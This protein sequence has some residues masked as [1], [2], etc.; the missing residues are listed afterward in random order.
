MVGVGSVEDMWNNRQRVWSVWAWTTCSNVGLVLGPIYGAYITAYLNW[1]WSFYIATIVM[2]A[3][4]V[5]SFFVQESRPTR[6]LQ[7]KLEAVR[8]ETGHDEVQIHNP[9]HLP[10]AQEFIDVALLRPLKLFFTEPIVFFCSVMIGIAFGLIYGLTESLT[11]VYEEFGFSTQATTLPFIAILVGLLLTAFS[12]L[13]DL[14]VL[15]QLAQDN[16]TIDPE[17]KIRPYVTAITSLVIGLWWFAWT[18]PPRAY[19]HWIVPTISLVLIGVAA[20]DF[21]TVLCGYLSDAYTIYASS[22]F[23][24]VAA[25]R[26]LV[27][28]G[29]AL[30][31]Y[32]M[33]TNLDPNIATSILAVISTI[34]AVTP[35]IFLKYGRQLRERSEF[36]R[37][38]TRMEKKT[39]LEAGAAGMTEL[40]SYSA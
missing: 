32:P 15:G 28:A 19:T 30:W 5:G 26:A 40:D 38:S 25:C 12:R 23:A 33:Y 8:K 24:A 16:A 36:A 29:F 1:R 20:N 27:A 11:I 7:R 2:A 4:T 14:R 22:A 6:L 35:W 39:S 10:T 9:D 21:D 3:L 37:Y 18:I 13:Y 34:F 31:T 17:A